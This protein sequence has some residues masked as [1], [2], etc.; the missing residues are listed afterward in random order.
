MKPGSLGQDTVCGVLNQQN[1]G[2]QPK[3]MKNHTTTLKKH[4]NQQKTM[5]LPLKTMETNQKP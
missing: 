4:G 5:K 2:N 1:Y 3:T